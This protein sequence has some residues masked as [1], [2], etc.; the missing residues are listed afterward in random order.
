MLK[1]IAAAIADLYLIHLHLLHLLLCLTIPVH[2]LLLLLPLFLP[3]HPPHPHVLSLVAFRHFP[4]HLQPRL[5]IAHLA[6]AMAT[7]NRKASAFLHDYHEASH[8]VVHLCATARYGT[9]AA[10]SVPCNRPQGHHTHTSDHSIT[11]VIP[12]AFHFLNLHVHISFPSHVH[13]HHH[14][15][16]HISE[17]ALATSSRMGLVRSPST[18]LVALWATCSAAIVLISGT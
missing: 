16:L 18:L 7:T 12:H 6:I 4:L 2:L 10:T 14:L 15:H 13:H 17:T 8:H 5:L 9:K 3:I 11:H 1:N